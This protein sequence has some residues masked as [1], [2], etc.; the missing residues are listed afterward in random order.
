MSAKKKKIKIPRKKLKPYF[1]ALEK[2]DEERWNKIEELEDKM[3]EEFGIPD[4]LLPINKTLI[5]R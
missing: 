5:L 4:I 2:I 3:R 1:D